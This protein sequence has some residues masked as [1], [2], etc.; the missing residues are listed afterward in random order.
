M[1]ERDHQGQAPDP[2]LTLHGPDP[3]VI[4]KTPLDSSLPGGIRGLTLGA[5]AATRRLLREGTNPHPRL[6]SPHA[7]EFANS[8]TGFLGALN[9]NLLSHQGAAADVFTM[10]DEIG[11][12]ATQV[13]IAKAT[14]HPNQEFARYATLK[15]IKPDTKIF[16]ETVR[17]LLTSVNAKQRLLVLSLLDKNATAGIEADRVMP[18]IEAMLNGI[19]DSDAPDPVA[20]EVPSRLNELQ[21]KNGNAPPEEQFAPEN[22]KLQAAII[23][24]KLVERTHHE[25][26]DLRIKAGHV[27]KRV[28]GDFVTYY[29]DEAQAA[30][31]KS[32]VASYYKGNARAAITSFTF[33]MQNRITTINGEKIRATVK[34]LLLDIPPEFKLDEPFAAMHRLYGDNGD[35]TP[36]V[37]KYTKL[38]TVLKVE[39][40]KLAAED[41]IG[42][43]EIELGRQ[44][45]ADAA[46]VE[47]QLTQKK[48]SDAQKAAREAA[49]T[50]ALQ[51]EQTVYTRAQYGTVFQNFRN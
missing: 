8:A 37:D 45:T 24:S 10:L 5:L 32:A 26:P 18:E 44:K 17:Q 11:Q 29:A 49:R 7:E 1:N 15:L 31:A 12:P 23:Y 40:K 21:K 27:L 50:A 48:R 46:H 19:L 33:D 2:L 35:V 4:L 13:V 41:L 28:F 25:N 34:D 6:A 42:E 36:E 38:I 3:I 22:L 9:P 20:R 30:S 47:A 16:P 51:E 39:A 14:D 43:L